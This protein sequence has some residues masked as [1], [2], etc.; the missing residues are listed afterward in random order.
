MVVD[1]AQGKQSML[2]LL[3]LHKGVAQGL[4]PTLQLPHHPALGGTGEEATAGHLPEADR[5]HPK[6]NSGARRLILGT[7]GALPTRKDQGEP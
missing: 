4:A 1:L 7:Q 6:F 2:G 3:E 5:T